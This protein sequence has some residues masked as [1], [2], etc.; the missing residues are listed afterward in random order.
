MRIRALL[1]LSCLFL[2]LGLPSCGD[3][4]GDDRVRVVV[5]IPPQAWVVARIGGPDVL[6]ETLVG[7]GDS[8]ATH[9]PTD[10]QVSAVMRAQAWFSMGVPFENGAW[11]EAI[12]ST[13]QLRIVN[14]QDGALL[15]EI[16]A[17][18]PN[19]HAH[20]DEH[21]HVHVGGKCSH[22]GLDPHLWLSPS[23]LETIAENVA[24][25][26]AEIDPA[27]AERY[28]AN[29]E[30]LRGE[31]EALDE[32]LT[33]MLEPW[34]G[35]TIYVFHPA[36][37]YFCDA[38]GLEQVAI[39]ISGQEPSESELTDLVRRAKEDQA[40]VVFVQSQIQGRS[41]KALADAIGAEVRF[42]DPLAQDV[43][44]N[45]RAVARALVDALS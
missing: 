13:G 3:D 45:L 6:V 12:E 31:L 40:K 8:P 35:R 44:K 5:S 9:Q 20:E 33:E 34:D 28:E 41:A 21:G 10:A 22:D 27:N 17:H 39:E 23:G 1:L 4:A 36:W 11:R 32:E 7:P 19:A 15:R 38:Y 25:G 43:P 2:A 26:L 37:G 18:G 24:E 16:E 42:L 30:T 14:T 29:L